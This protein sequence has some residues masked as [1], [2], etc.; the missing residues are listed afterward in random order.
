MTQTQQQFQSDDAA[1]K[2]KHA[3]M[4]AMGDYPA[5]ATE[6]IAALG[7]VLVEATGIAAGD[8]VLDIAAGSGNASIPA[9][10]AGADVVA[11]DLTPDLIETGRQAAERVG[12]QLRW[13]VADAEA[14]PYADAEFDAAISCVGVMFAPHH[15]VAADELRARGPPRRPDRAAQLDAGRLHRP[16]VRHHEALRT[17]AARPAPSRRRCGATRR[18]CASCSATGSPT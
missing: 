17:A 2:A 5:V 11:S 1:L 16:D 7:P 12:A 18:T 10:L 15:Q 4:W 6:V 13:E 8:H 14:L 3:A 9:A